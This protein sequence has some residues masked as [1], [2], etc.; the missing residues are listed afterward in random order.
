MIDFEKIWQ[1]YHDQLHGFVQKRVSDAAVAEDIVQDIF[2]K[3]FEKTD[4]LS[5]ITHLKS[6]IYQTSRNA[7]IDHY[8]TR[9]IPAELSEHLPEPDS[10]KSDAAR[11]EIAECLKPMMLMLPKNYREPVWMA[12]LMGLP[13]KEIAQ[14]L[15]LSL[16][17]TKSRILRGREL[18][19]QIY[20]ACCRV[21][22][23]PTGN[24]YDYERNDCEKC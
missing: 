21:I 12:D 17:A 6:W 8:R 20:L 23:D 24:I 19:K 9:K 1:E 13:Q 11:Q 4:S 2:L 10:E 3:I 14:K 18:L 15:N 5:D 7:I 22:V 16:S